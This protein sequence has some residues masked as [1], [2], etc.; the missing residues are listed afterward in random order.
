LAAITGAVWPYLDVDNLYGAV[1]SRKWFWS[2][3][4]VTVKM[5]T[6]TPGQKNSGFQEMPLPQIGD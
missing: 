6:A 4:A 5:I 2:R 3:M 1:V